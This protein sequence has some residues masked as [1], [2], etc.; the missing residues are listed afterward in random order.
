MVLNPAPARPLPLELLALVDVLTPN[1]GEAAILSSRLV[2]NEAAARDAAQALLALGPRAVVLTL[3]ARGALVTTSEEMITIEGLR[4][5][6][7]DTTAAGDA[8]NGALAVALARGEALPRAVRYAC[9]AGALAVTKMG[10]QPS[11]PTMA[12]MEALLAAIRGL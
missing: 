11:L 12:E 1:E 7:V 2:D 9:A 3:G 8:F 10:A 5:Q 6:V 4:V